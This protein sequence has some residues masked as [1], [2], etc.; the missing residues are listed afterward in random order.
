MSPHAAHVAF[1]ALQYARQRELQGWVRVARWLVHLEGTDW[2][3]GFGDSETEVLAGPE[4][5]LPRTTVQ[6]YRRVFK[7]FGLLPEDELE[8]VRPRFLFQACEAVENGAD[9]AEVLADA[10]VLSWSAFVQKWNPKKSHLSSLSKA[11]REE[12]WGD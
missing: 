6:Q 11:E 2:Y 3:K 8:T 5:Q 7:A 1:D 9:P 10:Q 12:R 4:F